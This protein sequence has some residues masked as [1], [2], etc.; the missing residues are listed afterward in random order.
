MTV[1][2]H[3]LITDPLPDHVARCQVVFC[4]NVLIYF[5]TEH[6]AALL[7]KYPNL[8]IDTAARIPEMG[9]YDAA[10]MR[11]L[12]I[13]FQDRIVFGSDLVVGE[14]YDWDHYA[15]RYWALQMTWETHYHG[16]SNIDDPDL[17][18]RQRYGGV[19]TEEVVPEAAGTHAVTV[20]G[21]NEGQSA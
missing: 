4:R 19:G 1:Q 14:K 2:H 8:Y 13:E 21:G 3:N 11:A 5:S 20:P 6:V 10:K 12:F 9:R 7:R 17:G 15:S 16:E 18:W